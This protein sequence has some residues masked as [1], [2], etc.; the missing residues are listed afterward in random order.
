MVGEVTSDSDKN[1]L[2]WRVRVALNA[3]EEPERLTLDELCRLVP[4]LESAAE[5]VSGPTE[6]NVIAF[7]AGRRRQVSN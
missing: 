1:R 3:I 6:K 2:V 5:R 4:T 7:A